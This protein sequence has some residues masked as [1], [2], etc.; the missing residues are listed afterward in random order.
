MH[1]TVPELREYSYNID[2][3]DKEAYKDKAFNI[4][5]VIHTCMY[6]YKPQGHVDGELAVHAGEHRGEPP[7]LPGVGEL[8]DLPIRVS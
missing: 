6:I 8:E 1:T 5:T 4:Y 7:A 2:H 3:K